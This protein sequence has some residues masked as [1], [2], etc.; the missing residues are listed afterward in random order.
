MNF[1]MSDLQKAINTSVNAA[2]MQAIASGAFAASPAASPA[3]VP[4]APSSK[5]GQP[6]LWIA[7]KKRYNNKL[8][9][10]EL[11]FDGKPVEPIRRYVHGLGFN[12]NKRDKVWWAKFDAASDANGTEAV[13]RI[14]K[15]LTMPEA[16]RDE[17]LNG[18]KQ[19][20]EQAPAPAPSPAPVKAE[21]PAP[22]PAP[23]KQAPLHVGLIFTA[24][25]REGA[26]LDY[27]AVDYPDGERVKVKDAD[28][29]VGSYELH[30]T[31]RGRLFIIVNKRPAI[32]SK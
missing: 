7:P 13:T 6:E 18:K 17:F 8:N 11:V 25:T 3:S 19:E 27:I 15:A 10:V 29:K 32:L 16:K 31:D 23:A 1:T 28:G 20:A 14:S 4:A 30:K 12:W 2:L 26:E 22:S 21:A 24:V 5:K 9:G